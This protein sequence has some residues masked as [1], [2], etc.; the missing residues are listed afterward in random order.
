M[1]PT[2]ISGYAFALRELAKAQ[3]EGKLS[4]K[5]Q[6]IQSGGEPLSQ[7]NKTYIQDTFN[8]EVVNVYA[9]SEHLLTGIGKRN[10]QGMYLMEDNLIFEIHPQYTNITNLYNYTLPLIR[11][12]MS[13]WLLPI[14]DTTKNMPF[15]KIKNIVGRNEHI[16]LFI[17]DKGEEDFISPHIIG[18][19]Y[20]EHLTSFQFHILDKKSFVYKAT[21]EKNI[22]EIEKKQVIKDIEKNLKNILREKMMTKVKF[23]IEIVNQIWADPKTGKFKLITQ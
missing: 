1:Q 9:S 12:Q 21:L 7:E 5:P 2:I 20:V 15:I 16:P 14:T 3:K 23:T 10:F 22:T 19:F 4:I 18:E 13:D 6:I 8:V 17:N 11:Y